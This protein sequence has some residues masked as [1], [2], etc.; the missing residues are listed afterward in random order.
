MS[1][2]PTRNRLGLTAS[3]S[4]PHW[5]APPRPREGAPNVVVIVFDDLGFADLGC[6][7]SEIAT[8]NIDALATNGLRYTNFHTT[9]LCSPTRAALLTGRNHHSVGMGGLA[10]WDLGFPGMRGRI[11][12]SAGTLAE[13]LRGAGY[14]TFAVGKWHL[15]PTFETSQAGPFDQWPLQRGFDR[16]Y[17]FLEGET[18][19]WHPELVLDNHHIE[20]PDREGYHLSEDLIDQSI[21]FVRAQQAVAPGKPFLLYLCLGAQHAPHHAPKAF[22]D[23]YVPVFEKGWDRTREERLARQ[24]AMGIVPPDTLLPERNPGVKAWDALS[25]DERRLAVR[26]Q[27]AFAGMLEHADQQIGR[28]VGW[29]RE[30]GCL[31]NTLLTLISDNGASQEGSPFGTVNALRYFNGVRDTLADNLPHLEAIGEAHLNNNYPLGWAMAGNTPLK[32][33]KQNTHGGGVRDPLIVHWPA[34]IPAGGGIRHQFHHVSDITPTV[35]EIA[36]ISAP[37]EIAGVAQQ[38]I[39]GTSFAYSFGEAQAPTRKR[40]QYFEML[41]HRA[42]WHE[43]WKAVTVHRPGTRFEDDRWELYHVAED[44]NEMHDLAE[45]QPERLQ[46]MIARWFAQAGACNVLPLDDTLNRFVSSNPHSIAA[47]RHWVLLPGAGRIPQ[48]AAPDIRNRSYR[49]VAH[50]EIPAGGADGV[51]IAQG[52]WCGG[53]A[54]YLRDGHLVHDY[55]FVNRHYVARSAQPVPPGMH[56]L[57]WEVRKTGEYRGEGTLSIDGVPCGGVALPQTY[58]AQ[59][60]FIGLEVGRAPKPAVGDFEAPFPFTGRLLRVEVVLA[61]DQRTDEAMAL[62]SAL[63][64]Q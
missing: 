28:L 50:V 31:D 58:R 22:V 49:I 30:T 4:E 34:G 25:D 47:R 14:N 10:D 20:A 38:P 13:M 17:G 62:E 12:R 61:D 57:A 63:R 23:R 45:A 44:F 46:A 32:R 8:P 51:L 53:Y 27:A 24:K 59:S 41:G 60:S 16:Y 6:Y 42:I 2:N 64:R 52:D 19:Q 29:L 11:A 56:Q 55:N 18:S 39:E 54:F 40:T 5:P 3:E 21:G 9:A 37:A 48:A 26:L 1:D 15:T 33:Y 35:L 43:G 7:G 36:G